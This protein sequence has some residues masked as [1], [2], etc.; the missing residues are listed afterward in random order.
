MQSVFL[1]CICFPSNH[2]R[3]FSSPAL[4]QYPITL[5]ITLLSVESTMSQYNDQGGADDSM[6][7][8]DPSADPQ[9]QGQSQGQGQ[10]QGGGRFPHPDI[11]EQYY[12]KAVGGNAAQAAGGM[13]G[14]TDAQ[15][16]MGSGQSDNGSMDGA[17]GAMTAM[18][19]AGGV[20]HSTAL[21]V[22]G[23]PQDNG[24]TKGPHGHDVYAAHLP[25]W[26]HQRYVRSRKCRG[27][28]N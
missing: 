9:G 25:H 2:L 7:G 22:H 11:A 27:G 15:G 12:H 20:G 18:G 28:C 13:N 3:H 14:A 17:D 8:Q 1:L 23:H 16:N 6:G 4:S 19:A 26:T 21:D 24:I 5:P 10:A